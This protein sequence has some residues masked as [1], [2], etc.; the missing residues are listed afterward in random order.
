MRVMFD[1]AFF[2]HLVQTNYHANLR[3]LHPFPSSF[4]ADIRAV[5]RVD[6]ADGTSWT[7]RVG[8]ADAP[9]PD[10]LV[11]CGAATTPD[12][13]RSRAATLQYLEEHAYP[14][15]RVVATRS[16]APIGQ[17]DGWCTFA[18]TFIEGP[19]TDPTPHSLRGIAAA[20]GRL[21]HIQLDQPNQAS[22]QPG[23]S[24]WFPGVAIPAVLQQFADLRPILPEEWH[25][26]ADAFSAT[27][28]RIFAHDLPPAI[29]HG[30]G[31]AGNAV[32]TT[33]D[34]TILIDW[35]PSG[36]GLAVLDVGRLL[37]HCHQTLAAPTTIPARI[38]SQ[39]IAAVVDGCHSI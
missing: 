31:W 39:S 22:A 13:L 17:A 11:G 1:L 14:A 38:S 20:L 21:H 15:P 23:Q 26:T 6:L 30:D 29:I 33:T 37:L 2:S 24:W 10:W 28:R 16:G 8:K 4:V 12:W 35:E 25:A 9:V 7:L 34:Q 19:V 27:L 3:S 5:C 18:A 32:Q 36:Q